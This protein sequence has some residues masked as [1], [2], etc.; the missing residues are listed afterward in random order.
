M[1]G[2]IRLTLEG[3]DR[4]KA[5]LKDLEPATQRRVL[6]PAITQEATRIAREVKPTLPRQTGLLKKSVGKLVK[7]YAQSHTVVGIVGPRKGFAQVIDG[8]KHDPAKYGHLVEG[9]VR[10]HLITIT[11]RHGQPIK[12]F[13]IHHPGYKGQ[14]P[15]AKAAKA[16]TSGATERLGARIG[17]EIEKLAA[18][19]KL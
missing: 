2:S 18:K 8:R 9:D 14:H 10:P 11:K 15:F 13:V 1:S 5:L 19:G 16:A 17:Q 12:Q 4:L 3:A 7:T 6:R